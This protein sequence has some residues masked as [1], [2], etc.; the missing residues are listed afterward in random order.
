M[1]FTKKAGTFFLSISIK[2]PE[3]EY[4]K[5]HEELNFSSPH[6]GDVPE[7]SLNP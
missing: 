6:D 2:S 7:S 4:L 1:S 3:P 5:D